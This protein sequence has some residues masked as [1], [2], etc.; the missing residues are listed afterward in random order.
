MAW[1]TLG[2]TWSTLVKLGQLWSNLVKPP[3]TLGEVLGVA[4]WGRFETKG[5]C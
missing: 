1:S 4:S 3:Q 5:P 2:Q